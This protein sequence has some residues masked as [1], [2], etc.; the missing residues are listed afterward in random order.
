[1]IV[2]GVD[3]GTQSLKAVAADRDLKLMGSAS[4]AYPFHTPAPGAAE[5]DPQLWLDALKPAIAGCLEAAGASPGDVASLGFVGQL[6]GC[7]GVD[8]SCR[9]LGPALIWMDR[10]AQDEIEDIPAELVRGRTGSVLDPSHM[11]AKIRWLKR[12]AGSQEA[13]RFHQPVSFV[14]ERLTGRAIFDHGLASTTMLYDLERRCYCDE[15]LAAF[16]ISAAEL[17][18]IGEAS[19]LAGGLTTAGSALTGLPEGVP[20]AIG[21]G[22]DFAG[23]LGA[24][25][26]TPGTVVCSLGTAE[27][28]GAVHDHP[29]ID[30]SNLVETHGYVSGYSFIENPGWLSGGA[31]TWLANLLGFADPAALTEA[32]ASVPAGSGGVTFIPALNGA[33]APVWAPGASGVFHGLTAHH[34]RGYLARAVLEGC[35]FAMRDVV[36][37]LQRLGVS[38]ERVLLI[39]GGARSALWAEI[40]AGVLNQNVERAESVD[41]APMAAVLLAATAAGLEP[42]LAEAAARVPLVTSKVAPIRAD[43]VVY[44]EAYQR[45]LRLF[46]ALMPLF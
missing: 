46:R 31:L 42:S 5:Q 7:I 24:G 1:M 15:L 44:E 41:A 2:I 9:A 12:R 13:M 26:V 45:Y 40:R 25:I 33:M 11:A 39:G 17:P 19:A 23:P 34:H 43:V 18:Q 10:R 38:T 35:A 29:L 27:V 21:T 30:P 20:V 32:A 14:V 37:Q 22:D 8:A 3:I 28:V 36:N 6:D 4:V 16:G